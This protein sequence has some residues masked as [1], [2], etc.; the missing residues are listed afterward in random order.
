MSD[1]DRWISFH[2]ITG[3]WVEPEKIIRIDMGNQ[4]DV[5]GCGMAGLELL[6]ERGR[7]KACVMPARRKLG[8]C[9]PLADQ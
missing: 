4:T 6:E 1:F 3:N 8:V 5:I 9:G 7:W 2:N